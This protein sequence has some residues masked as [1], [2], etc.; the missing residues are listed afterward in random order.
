MQQLIL[1]ASK[2]KFRRTFKHLLFFNINTNNLQKDL[3][4]YILLLVT[5]SPVGLEPKTSSSTLLL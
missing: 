2:F 1:N 4:H 5:H 3:K